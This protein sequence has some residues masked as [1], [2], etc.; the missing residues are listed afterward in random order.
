MY[1]NQ[2]DLL[3]EKFLKKCIGVPQAYFPQLT[4]K[5]YSAKASQF[6]SFDP[7]PVPPPPILMEMVYS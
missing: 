3:I 1:I 4:K 5:I 2:H 6:S 7:I